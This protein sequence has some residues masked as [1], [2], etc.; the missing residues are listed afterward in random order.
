MSAEYPVP[1]AFSP[2]ADAWMGAAISPVETMENTTNRSL[3]HR[4]LTRTPL[5][6]GSP[7]PAPRRA[8]PS[9]LLYFNQPLSRTAARY[10]ADLRDVES[11]E[12]RG[13]R[14]VRR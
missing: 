9:T 13:G 6:V 5:E 12:R 4:R 8:Y 3:N 1:P 7:R 2:V 14:G 10:A 11:V